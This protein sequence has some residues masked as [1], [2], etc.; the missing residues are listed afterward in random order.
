MVQIFKEHLYKTFTLALPVII[1][2]LGF[3]MM[4][5]VDSVMVGRLG[6]VP[7]AAAALGSSITILI[8]IIGL[9]SSVAVTPL[10]AILI[11]SKRLEESGIYFKQSLFI[12][13]QLSII[14]FLAIFFA[15]YLIPYMN[16]PEDVIPHAE[17]YTRILSLSVLP[18]MIFQTYKQFIEGFSIMRPAMFIAIAANFINA[19]SNWIFIY[20]NLGVPA[21]GLDGA[22]IATVISRIFMAILLMTYVTKSKHFAEFDVSLKIRKL[23]YPIIKKILSLGIPSGFQYF[24]ETGAFVFAI[25]MVGWIG[26][27]EQAAHQIAINLA[28]ISFM[29]AIGISHAGSIRVG[30]AVGQQNITEIR[31]SGFIAVLMGGIIMML[32]GITFILLKDFLPSLYVD[33]LAVVE[34]ASVLLIIAAFFQIADGVQAVGI[35]ILRGLTDIKGP[36]LITFIAYWIIGL[37]SGYL[38]GF[39]LNLGVEGVWVGL[40]LGLFCSATFLTLRFNYKSRHPVTI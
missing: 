1:G 18:Q 40:S 38:F 36:T 28:S 11:G 9:G 14:L 22:G 6:A 2:Q 21:Y 20:G 13:V 32:A 7:L 10:V 39:I 12:N 26:A 35:G 24:F 23:N 33:D 29:M 27:N 3:M 34:I 5:V 4:G 15:S 37:P 30:N 25:V 17:S 19:F 31:R 16:Q 8:F